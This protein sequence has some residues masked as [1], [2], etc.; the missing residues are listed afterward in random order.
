MDWR[1]RARRQQ[2]ALQ[3]LENVQGNVR[4]LVMHI[5]AHQ[6]PDGGF[7]QIVYRYGLPQNLDGIGKLALLLKA[8]PTLAGRL[9]NK[10]SNALAWQSTRRHKSGTSLWHQINHRLQRF[11]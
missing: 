10:S 2:V 5:Q 11:H 6:C 7:V 4:T 3:L 8:R 1:Q 9:D